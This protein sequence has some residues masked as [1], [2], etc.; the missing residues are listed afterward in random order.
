MPFAD[1]TATTEP[2]CNALSHLSPAPEASVPLG[3]VETSSEGGP[4]T[5]AGHSS[6][7]RTGTLSLEDAVYSPEVADGG[8]ADAEGSVA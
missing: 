1:R 6:G 3:R 2:P 7:P 4:V 5:G 8:R